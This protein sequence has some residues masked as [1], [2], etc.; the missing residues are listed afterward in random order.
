MCILKNRPEDFIENDKKFIMAKSNKFI[1]LESRIADFN[2]RFDTGDIRYLDFPNVI[3]NTRNYYIHSDESIK[4][5][6]RVLANSEL[7][8]YNRSLINI[9]EY[10]IL[11]ELGFS[12]IEQFR[13]KLKERWGNVSDALTIRKESERMENKNT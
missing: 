5:R 4:D 10:Y 1:T 6:G 13:N 11:L 7:A 9:L 2:I 8:I 3:A 12:N